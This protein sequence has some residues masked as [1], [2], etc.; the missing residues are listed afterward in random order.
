MNKINELNHQAKV[1]PEGGFRGAG[2]KTCKI[3]KEIRTQIAEKNDIEYITSECT[4][5]GECKGTCPKCEEEVRYLE[6]ELRK[7]Q[8]L[9]K[10]VTIAGISLGVAGSFAACGN[11]QMQDD[12]HSA[13]KL[14]GMTE[15]VDTPKVTIVNF[16]ETANVDTI[17]PKCNVV[18]KKKG[19]QELEPKDYPYY[20]GVIIDPY[21]LLGDP[22]TP[23]IDQSERIERVPDIKA[24]YPGGMPALMKFLNE[25]INYPQDALDEGA[26]GIVIVEFVIKI[27][28]SIDN[29]IVV[30]K[31]HPSL[32]KE[33]IRV[34]KLM[35]KW[36]PGSN[37]RVAVSSYFQLPVQF[38]LEKPKPKLEESVQK[39]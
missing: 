34:V 29:V 36:K 12:A 2:K 5:Q 17:V 25:N 9:G 32:D 30:K 38:K 21:P 13:P 23:P 10:V 11:S 27:D 28:G 20:E 22:I 26:S 37:N 31:V 1:P 35:P 24:E 7:R 4:F 14:G 33:A 15:F 8:Q 18:K 6:N 16:T 39:E 19:G 3:L